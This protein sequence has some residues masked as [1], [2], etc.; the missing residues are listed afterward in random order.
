MKKIILPWFAIL[1]LITAFKSDKPAYQLFDSKGKKVNYEKLLNAVSEADIVFFGE[2]HDSP[3]CHWLEYELVKDFIETKSGN[4]MLGFEM[5]ESDIQLIVNEYLEGKIKEK[6]FEEEAKIWKNYKTDYKPL[7]N[8]ARDNKLQVVATNIP[9]RY[10]A[11][12]NKSGFESLDSL[13]EEAKKYIAPLPVRYDPELNCYK[14]M[15]EN[16]DEMGKDHASE[17][18]PKAQAVKDATMAYFILRNYKPGA[19]FIHFNGTYHSDNFEGIVWY[20]RQEKPDLKIVTLSSV[21]QSDIDQLTEEN[22]NLGDFILCIPESMT[23]TN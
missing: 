16:T 7:I 6:N 8:L 10:A 1:L 22:I 17:N 15:L 4:V 19:T 13:N 12:V 9:R 5:F 18:L 2:L 20:I 3:I 11:L 21:E 14:S 23:K